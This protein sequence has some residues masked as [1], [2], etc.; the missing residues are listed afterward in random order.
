MTRQARPRA[1]QGLSS[2]QAERLKTLLDAFNTAARVVERIRFDPI[3]FPGR[4]Q[5]PRDIEVSGLLA[6][7]L[8]YG[9]ADLFKPKIDQLLSHMGTSPAD[10]VAGLT[11]S[12]AAKLLDG[13][14]YR[15]NLAADVG[16]LLIGIQQALAEHGSL[17][18][19]FVSG[20]KGD[21]P[22]HSALDAFTRSL[23][24]VPLAPIEKALGPTRG[25]GH[26][27]PAP[28]G[29]GAAKRLNLYLRWM[30]RGP[31]AV[32]FGIWKQVS[33]AALLVPLDTH[34]ARIAHHLGLTDRTDLSWRTAE[35]I[36][37]S[38]R[39]L[40]PDDPVKYDFA[41]CHYGMS[42]ICPA[43]PIRENCARCSLRP[44]CRGR[45]RGSRKG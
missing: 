7:A 26:L 12:R 22:L 25:L 39:R 11:L 10:F 28:L 44:V 21:A 41:L 14:V 24:D 40:D 19:L 13:F 15:F 32:D 45:H 1:S 35:E 23:R 34:V 6:A 37:R 27:L 16:V 38:L 18:A 36:T 17:D 31:D 2:Q 30:V 43:A 42:G 3:E 20:L 9:R 33:P 4:Y 5:H 8:A 29:K